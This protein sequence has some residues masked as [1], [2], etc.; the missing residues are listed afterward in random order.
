MTGEEQ[1]D[2]IRVAIDLAGG[3]KRR[4]NVPLLPGFLG[5]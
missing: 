5:H 2:L 3:Q 4:K 1:A